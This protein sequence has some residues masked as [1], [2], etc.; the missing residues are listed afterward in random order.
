MSWK[1]YELHKEG[2]DYVILLVD[3]ISKDDALNQFADYMERRDIPA[4]Y[5][6]DGTGLPYILADGDRYLAR[7]TKK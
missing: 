1:K 7:E 2:D 3:A 5:H 4:F 6:R